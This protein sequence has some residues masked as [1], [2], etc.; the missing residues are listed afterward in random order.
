RLVGAGTP[1]GFPPAYNTPFA[2]V[3]FVFETIIGIAT[4]AALLPTMGATVIAAM[5]TRAL[6]GAGPIYGQ[7]AF[8]VHAFTD[9]WWLLVLGL[10]AAVVAAGFKRFLAVSEMLS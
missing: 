6:A 1:A 2:A 4:P 9:L 5:V 10:L 8:A 7:R 3:L